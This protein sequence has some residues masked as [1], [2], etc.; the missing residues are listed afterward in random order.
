MTL[1]RA[2][3]ACS[4]LLCASAAWSG[5]VEL[6]LRIP[7]EPLREALEAQLGF[8]GTST[9]VMHREGPCR[10][11]KVGR[12]ELRADGGRLHI[13]APGSALVAVELLGACQGLAPW[14][15]QMHFVV[16]PYLDA[17]GR[18]RVRIA[19]SRLTDPGGA[20][21]PAAGMLWD[22]AK[23]H[24]H[25]RLERFSFDIGASREALLDLVR[26]AAPP[27][28]AAAL[29]VSLAQ[30]QVLQ[31]RVEASSVTVPIAFE[32][33]DAWLSP[34]PAA[35]STAPLT[36]AEL[37]ALDAALQPLDA[38]LV[39]SL[40]QVALDSSDNALRARLFTLLLDSRYQLAAIL[41]GEARAAGDPARAL[42]IDAWNDLRAI[43]ADAQREGLLGAS[44]LRYALFTE[45]GD[46]LL[47]LDRAA[48]GFGMH[49]SADGLRQL[50]RSLRP[51]ETGDPLTFAWAVDPQLLEL[52]DV[53][54][55]PAPSPPP[56]VPPPAPPRRSWLD[57]IIRSAHATSTPA[58][59]DATNA[60]DPWVPRHDELELYGALI[61]RLLKTTTASAL[62]RGGLPAPYTKIYERLVPATALIESCW[63]QYEVRGGKVRYLQSPAHSVGIMQIN[64]RVWRGFYDVQRLRWDTAYNARA[65]AQILK[66]YLKDYAIPY[67]ERSGNLDHVPR[68]AYAV[69]N[70]GPRAVGRFNKREPHPREARVD[71]RLWTLYRGIAAGGRPD[72]RT[73][74][75]NNAAMARQ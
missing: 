14:H 13:A 5:R 9:D 3:V 20:G 16:A 49:V 51:G 33:P 32:I 59:P 65:G 21:T 74:S 61:S 15:G 71:E 69:Y 34:A 18:V 45:A 30:L 38:F 28:Q 42:F 48:P 10:Y 40:K 53:A 27:E 11:L 2:L 23:R 12:P 26:S 72:L 19:D 47:A 56:L 1:V 50:A 64:Q 44:A 70:A 24:V 63:R 22:L 6:P 17:A 43:L 46:A 67:A 58:H 75:V 54:P 36:E 68:A 60:L 62:D 29:E 66:R 52:F 31:P 4:I 39:Y 37:E 57:L 55:L 41:S 73:C 25:T 35:A 8:S 7:L